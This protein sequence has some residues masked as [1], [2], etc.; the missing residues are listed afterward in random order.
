MATQFSK[1]KLAE[2]QEKKEKV[3]LKEGLL[4]RKRCRDNKPS[5]GD[6][7]VVTSSTILP[8][9][10]HPASSTSSL[11]MITPTNEVARSIGRDKAV[12]GTFW[13]DA[14]CAM[15]KAHNV[16][17]VE[18]LKPLMTKP[19]NELMLSHIQKIMQVCFLPSSYICMKVSP[20]ISFIF[21]CSR[22]WVTLCIS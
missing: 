5:K 10:R 1:G 7:H 11:E 14:N 17:S 16:I 6:N 3:G 9:L 12:V 8:A 20:L 13:D 22:R 4:L 18:D 19:S 2:V 15:A 21:L